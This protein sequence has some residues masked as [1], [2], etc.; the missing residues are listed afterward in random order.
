MSRLRM[1]ATVIASR[2]KRMWKKRHDKMT[3]CLI[4][5]YLDERHPGKGLG[6]TEMGEAAAR[7]YYPGL[8]DYVIYPGV[9]H[10][11]KLMAMDLE[12]HTL[13]GNFTGFEKWN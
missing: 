9:L 13:Y 6:I 12:F 7:Y 3:R 11:L 2:V 1:D 4:R 10:Y 8:D 5:A